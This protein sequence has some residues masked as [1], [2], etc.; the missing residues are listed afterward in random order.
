[1]VILESMGVLIFKINLYIISQRGGLE[2]QLYR[3]EGQ[4]MA[5]F[6]YYKPAII[7]D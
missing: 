3:Q 7:I 2:V 1:M 6:V 5:I 4:V